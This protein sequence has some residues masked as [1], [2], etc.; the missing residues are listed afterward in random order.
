MEYYQIV[1]DMLKSDTLVVSA[2]V[3]TID[4]KMYDLII[5]VR[6]VKGVVHGKK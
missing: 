3:F 5:E 2:G 6:E 1:K 4:D